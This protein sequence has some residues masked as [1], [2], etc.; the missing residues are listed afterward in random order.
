MERPTEARMSIR[1]I[2]AEDRAAWAPLW[3]GYLDFYET[4]LPERVYDETWRRLLDPAEPVWG[5]LALDANGTPVGLVHW[6]FHRTCWA[7][8]DSCYLQD[9]YVSAAARSGGHGRALIEHVAGTAR[10]AGASR[11]YWTTHESNATAQQLYDRL[12]ARSG[13]IQYRMAL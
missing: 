4:Q 7:V 13:F 8:A 11:L 10:A 9:L 3:T 5:A 12:A 1:A 6:L 2:T